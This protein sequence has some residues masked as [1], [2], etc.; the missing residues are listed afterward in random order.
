[1]FERPINLKPMLAPDGTPKRIGV[2]NATQFNAALRQ[3]ARETLIARLPESVSYM[4]IGEP[5]TALLQLLFPGEGVDPKD[6]VF[7][8]SGVLENHAKELTDAARVLRVYPDKDLFRTLATGS[9]QVKPGTR[10][11]SPGLVGSEADA[12]KSAEALIET[13]KEIPFRLKVLETAFRSRA[14]LPDP[15]KPVNAALYLESLASIVGRKAETGFAVAN[16]A[17]KIKAHL[18]YIVP[19]LD[20]IIDDEDAVAGIVIALG[21]LHVRENAER[22][23][24][25]G[26]VASAMFAQSV[27]ARFRDYARFFSSVWS[28]DA[29]VQIESMLRTADGLITL[30][31]GDAVVTSEVSDSRD[32]ATRGRDSMRLKL[33]SSLRPWISES[34]DGLQKAM[35]V[36]NI[37]FPGA[38]IK[39]PIIPGVLD[40]GAMAKS[41]KFRNLGILVSQ[42]DITLGASMSETIIDPEASARVISAAVGLYKQALNKIINLEAVLPPL[43]EGGRLLADMVIGPISVPDLNVPRLISVGDVGAF[44]VG[45]RAFSIREGRPVE[46]LSPY[47]NFPVNYSALSKAAYATQAAAVFRLRLGVMPKAGLP[48]NLG[49]SL[50]PLNFLEGERPVAVHPSVYD[51]AG[52]REKGPDHLELLEAYLSSLPAI[53]RAFAIAQLAGSFLVVTPNPGRFVDEGGLLTATRTE[54]IGPVPLW[55]LGLATDELL[56]YGISAHALIKANIEAIEKGRGYAYPLIEYP[57]SA[58]EIKLLPLRVTPDI[59]GRGITFEYVKVAA[60]VLMP[61]A[62]LL[63]PK[64]V[65]FE[66]T[67]HSSRRAIGHQFRWDTVTRWP[68]VGPLVHVPGPSRAMIWEEQLA[69]YLDKKIVYGDPSPWKVL[70]PPTPTA[71]I[72]VDKDIPKPALG[73]SAPAEGKTI[74]GGGAPAGETLDDA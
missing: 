41:A 43:E 52:E 62:S 19:M 11:H 39:L 30:V 33:A 15:K 18:A 14:G 23:R 25:S 5:E 61:C 71:D 7:A 48:G 37:L 34:M 16:N 22:L 68:G 67:L 54:K 26:D 17:D 45:I 10:F 49:A 72:P 28:L 50:I 70:P 47:L 13:E 12:T 60:D 24:F 27:S 1:M 4:R 42:T 8:R 65:K 66:V 20:R 6:Y 3:A 55:I 51:L 63:N 59:R 46:E 44:A 9:T 35:G 64:D 58:V 2:V 73:P 31:G 32:D 69:G 56:A 40:A 53:E 57:S 29:M 21:Y 36:D 38:K 74:E